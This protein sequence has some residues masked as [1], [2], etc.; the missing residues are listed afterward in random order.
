MIFNVFFALLSSVSA[1][2]LPWK[3]PSSDCQLVHQAWI[4]MGGDHNTF[5]DGCCK[6]GGITCQPDGTVTSIN[7]YNRQLS[8]PISDKLGKLVNLQLL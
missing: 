3:T 5:I 7:W 6:R 2:S 1:I 8:G 4:E